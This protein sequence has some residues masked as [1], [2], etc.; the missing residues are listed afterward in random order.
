MRDARYPKGLH[1]LPRGGL[2]DGSNPNGECTTAEFGTVPDNTNA[3][4]QYQKLLGKGL[5]LAQCQ[6]EVD[7]DPDCGDFFHIKSGSHC[8]C[9]RVGHT[10]CATAGWAGDYEIYT[11]LPSPVCQADPHSAAVVDTPGWSN[12]H[13]FDCAGYATKGRCANGGFKPGQEWTGG[14]KF[15]FP[16]DNCVVCGKKA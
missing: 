12:G 4:N 11:K 2:C 14:S 5:T 10:C 6:G 8:E 13:N 3:W 15:K 9:V 16:E 7:A 1:C